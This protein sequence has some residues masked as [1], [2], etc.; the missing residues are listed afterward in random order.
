MQFIDI[1][2]HYAWGIDD[3]IQTQEEAL[4]ALKI[5]RKNNISAI[6]ATPHVVPGTHNETDIQHFKD[7]IA[8]LKT[9]AKNENIEVYEGIL[10]YEKADYPSI[11][12]FI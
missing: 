9:L 10:R 7:R 6:V 11:P 12:N 4:E 8:N 2:G 3:G 5:A 1:H